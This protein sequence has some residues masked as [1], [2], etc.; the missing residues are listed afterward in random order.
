MITLVHAVTGTS[1]ARLLL[2]YVQAETKNHLLRYGWQ[3]AAALYAIA[4]H[5][6][7]T[8]HAESKLPDKEDLI[9][10][11]IKNGGAHPIKFTEACLREYQLNP[12]PVYLLAAQ[13]AVENLRG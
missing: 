2:P 8:N 6:P 4:G 1:A 3:L 11:A 13:H 10:R 9:D 5:T 12:K 7:T